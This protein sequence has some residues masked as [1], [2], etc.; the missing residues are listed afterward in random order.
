MGTFRPFYLKNTLYG[1]YRF[2]NLGTYFFKITSVFS[3]NP[4]CIIK[5]IFNSTVLSVNAKRVTYD[6]QISILTLY[7]AATGLFFSEMS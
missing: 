6:T 5:R 4:D 2:K 1:I 3:P 7:Q